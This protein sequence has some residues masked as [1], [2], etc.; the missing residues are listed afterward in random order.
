VDISTRDNKYR[1]IAKELLDSPC[2]SYD[3]IAKNIGLRVNYP[4]QSIYQYLHGKRFKAIMSEEIKKVYDKDELRE[5]VSK[6]LRSDSSTA[7]LKAAEL[8]MK[9]QAMLTERVETVNKPHDNLDTIDTSDLQAELVRRLR[10]SEEGVF[11][12]QSETRTKAETESKGAQ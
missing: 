12:C 2:Q 10:L 4:R 6:W 9:E 3:D 8:G 1:A 5:T 7:S 11:S